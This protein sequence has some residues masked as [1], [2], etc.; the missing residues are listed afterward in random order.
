MRLVER[1]FRALEVNGMVRQ[2][3]VIHQANAVILRRSFDM[4]RSSAFALAKVQIFAGTQ[5][6]HSFSCGC[7]AMLAHTKSLGRDGRPVIHLRA[8]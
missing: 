2:L 1:A 3:P 6:S 7:S 5:P 4:G 8:A